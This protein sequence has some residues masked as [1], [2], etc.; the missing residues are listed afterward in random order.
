MKHQTAAISGAAAN[1]FQS[2]MDPMLLGV[3]SGGG[4]GGGGGE[5]K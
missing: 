5:G 4:G 3:G 1:P 2:G